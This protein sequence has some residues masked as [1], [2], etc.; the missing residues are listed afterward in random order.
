M[1]HSIGESLCCEPRFP[2]LKSCTVFRMAQAPFRR[3]RQHDGSLRQN[4]AS[5]ITTFMLT[6]QIVFHPMYT[7]E[8]S[9]VKTEQSK[10][11]Q[12]LC[13]VLKIDPSFNS[14]QFPLTSFTCRQRNFA[15][16]TF[17]KWENEQSLTKKYPLLCL[18]LKF[19]CFDV[20]EI[21]QQ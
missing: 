17:A 6:V 11:E 4:K 20:C 12:S 13:S 10:T 1:A 16:G 5:A 7:R 18:H 9:F 19:Q 21:F 8:L 2:D 15:H 14:D 3:N